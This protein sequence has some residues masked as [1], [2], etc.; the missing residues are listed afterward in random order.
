MHERK[1]TGKN[2]LQ[3]PHRT[4]QIHVSR[5]YIRQVKSLASMLQVAYKNLTS[6]ECLPRLCRVS[7]LDLQ[8]LLP[9]TIPLLL[10]GVPSHTSSPVHPAEPPTAQVA[11]LLPN[12]QRLWRWCKMRGAIAM[13]PYYVSHIQRHILLLAGDH[14]GP[15]SCSIMTRIQKKNLDTNL[16]SLSE[17]S[18]PSR[19]RVNSIWDFFICP[20]TKLW[21]IFRMQLWFKYWLV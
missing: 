19:I 17:F 6:S 14:T 8:P 18:V 21:V 9:Q 5:G 3:P 11:Q 4:K 2:Y 12:T 16:A 13:H 15:A 1:E 7:G 20:F 10:P